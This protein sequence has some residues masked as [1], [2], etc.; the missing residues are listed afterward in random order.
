MSTENE[1]QVTSVMEGPRLPM[2]FR[3]VDSFYHFL[4]MINSIMHIHLSKSSSN[5]TVILVILIDSITIYYH[6]IQPRNDR[7]F[8]LVIRVGIWIFDVLHHLVLIPFDVLRCNLLIYQQPKNWPSLFLH[9][10][11]SLCLHCV[12]SLEYGE[13]VAVLIASLSDIPNRRAHGAGDM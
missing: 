8:Y 2:R 9:S 12:M 13:H 5:N 6:L 10:T 11:A 3:V 7:L 1:V 4:S